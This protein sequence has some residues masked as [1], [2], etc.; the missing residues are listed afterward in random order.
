MD[1]DKNESYHKETEMAKINSDVLQSLEPEK[2]IFG[3]LPILANRIQVV[4]D[5]SGEE[6]SLK[7][8]LLLIMI[9]QFQEEAPTLSEV[10]EALGSSRQNVKQLALKLQEKGFVKIE[11]DKKDARALKLYVTPECLAF[12]EKKV[13]YQNHFLQLLYE[14]MREDE[15]KAT[16]TGL[17]KL[18]LNIDK[19]EQLVKGGYKI[20]YL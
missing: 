4:A 18:M 17:Y 3:V 20:C 7:Q 16:A 2:V 13:D 14:G 6:V 8:W 10:A 1:K 9:L 5:S 11:Q 12:Y 15:M 19:M